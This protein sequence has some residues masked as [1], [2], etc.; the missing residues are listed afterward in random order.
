MQAAAGAFALA[1][2]R[3][4]DGSM[5]SQNRARVANNIMI[6]GQGWAERLLR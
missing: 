2:A 4:L 3:E 6:V 1:G 5:E